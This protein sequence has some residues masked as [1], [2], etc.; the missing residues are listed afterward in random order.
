[1]RKIP[2]LSSR[3]QEIETGPVM[4]EL[5][6]AVGRMLLQEARS[7]REHFLVFSSVSTFAET[8]TETKIQTDRWHLGVAGPWDWPA[9]FLN[10]PE[11]QIIVPYFCGLS[12]YTRIVIALLCNSYLW[13][14]NKYLSKTSSEAREFHSFG[15][16]H[17]SRRLWLS[18]SCALVWVFGTLTSKQSQ[19][20]SQERLYQSQSHPNIWVSKSNNNFLKF[21]CKDAFPL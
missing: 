13:I 9:H 18:K 15:S 7:V 17:K 8:L 4:Q 3:V 20:K 14:Y 12:C 16:W 2:I 21:L 5:K 19:T 10:P 11:E 6:V 1:M